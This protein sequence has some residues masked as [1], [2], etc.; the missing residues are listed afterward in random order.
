MSSSDNLSV[1]KKEQEDIN[2]PAITILTSKSASLIHWAE[3]RNSSTVPLLVMSP[4]CIRTSPLGNL[5]AASRVPY[6]WVSDTQTNLVLTIVADGPIKETW[7]T[8]VV[9]CRRYNR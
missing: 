5:K 1:V 9:G 4:A 6:P 3:L 8:G 2:K 7:Y